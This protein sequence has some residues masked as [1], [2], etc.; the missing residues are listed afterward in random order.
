MS[1]PL[2]AAQSSLGPACASHLLWRSE[3]KTLIFWA[4]SSASLDMPCLHSFLRFPFA[5]NEVDEELKG[6]DS[7]DKVNEWSDQLFLERMM[8]VAE[9][10]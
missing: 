5:Q 10:E 7:R 4:N 9:Q 1:C 2:T 3:I 8:S 6:V